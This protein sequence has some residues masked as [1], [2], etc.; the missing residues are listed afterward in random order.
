MLFEIK[1]MDIGRPLNVAITTTLLL[2][3]G[4]VSP[5]GRI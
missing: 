3:D 1:I 4:F 2:I 5:R